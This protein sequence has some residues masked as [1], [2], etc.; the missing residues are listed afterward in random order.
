ME[1]FTA[2][3]PAKRPSRPEEI[4]D[5]IGFLAGNEYMTG[6]VIGVDGGLA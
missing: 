1:Q 5:V 2:N 3:I 6:K 4:A